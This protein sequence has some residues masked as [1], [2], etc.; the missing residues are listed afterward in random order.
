MAVRPVSQI[1]MDVLLVCRHRKEPLERLRQERLIG[2]QGKYKYNQESADYRI[3]TKRQGDFTKAV[4]RPAPRVYG[5][6]PSFSLIFAIKQYQN[7]L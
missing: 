5:C 7:K 1:R 6:L 3:L 4:H 2:A